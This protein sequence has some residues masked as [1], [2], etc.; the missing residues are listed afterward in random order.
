MAALIRQFP[1]PQPRTQRSAFETLAR[2]ITGQQISVKA[3]DTLWSRLQQQGPINASFVGQLP[4]ATLRQCGYSQRKAEYLLDL[5]QQ[6]SRGILDDRLWLA[7]SDEA[8]IHSLTQIRGIGRWSAEMFLLFYLERPNIFPVED[9]GLRRALGRCYPAMEGAPSRTL[10]SF[11]ERWQ[12]WRS[13]ATWYL[14]R[15]L[16]PRE[17]TY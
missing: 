2:A 5:A 1:P 13:L 4:I 8:S 12:P 3:A 11:A 9:L 17:V 7:S 16:D 14:W 10:T 6:Q 15:S